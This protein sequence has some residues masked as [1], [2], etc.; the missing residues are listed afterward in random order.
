MPSMVGSTSARID[1][2]RQAMGD[3]LWPVQMESLD[4]ECP[5]LGQAAQHPVCFF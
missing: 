4:I 2:A 3:E 5:C 1:P